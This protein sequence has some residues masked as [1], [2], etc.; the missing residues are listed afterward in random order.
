MELENKYRE[1]IEGLGW[2]I[3]GPYEIDSNPNIEIESYSP[4]GENLVYTLF[5]DDIV[6]DARKLYENF[7]ADEHA[8]EWYGQPGAPGMR[9]LIEDGDDI[10]RMLEDLMIGL[11]Q[12]R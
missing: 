6:E 3:H 12:A 10:D 9:T 5:L 4:A 7:D 2:T 1:V 11:A 8:A